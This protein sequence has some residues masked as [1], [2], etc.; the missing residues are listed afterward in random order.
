M[1]RSSDPEILRY[2]NR[3][4]SIKVP[5]SVFATAHDPTDLSELCNFSYNFTISRI[6]VV[7]LS[8]VF[9][10]S[11]D[12]ADPIPVITAKEIVDNQIVDRVFF[13]NST[14]TVTSKSTVIVLQG[15]EY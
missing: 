14:T 5:G 10:L 8:G 11:L 4:R 7:Y 6:E 13:Q 2:K 12:R 1:K 9:S 3:Y 15:F